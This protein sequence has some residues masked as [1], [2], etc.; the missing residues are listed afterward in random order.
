[1]FRLTLSYGV[2][3]SARHIL[4]LVSGGGK[5][6]VVKTLF[7]DR[8][9]QLPAQSIRPPNGEVTW[10]LDQDAASLLSDIIPAEFD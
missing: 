2:L 8:R 4:F 6:E 1:M 7:E 9:A 10:L 3:N 5:A